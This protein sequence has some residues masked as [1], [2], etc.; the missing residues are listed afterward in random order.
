MKRADAKHLSLTL[1][2]ALTLFVVYL[3]TGYFRR[4]VTSTLAYEGTNA[5]YRVHTIHAPGLPVRIEGNI[6][7]EGERD[8]LKYTITNTSSAGAYDFEIAVYVLNKKGRVKAGQVWRMPVELAANSVDSFSRP[9]TNKPGTGDCVVVAIQEVTHGQNTW[10]VNAIPFLQS[11]QIAVTSD[12]LAT[13]S[14]IVASKPFWTV[15]S[16]HGAR[17]AAYRDGGCGDNF[18]ASQTVAATNACGGPT[19]C[20]VSSFSCD[21]TACTVSWSCNRCLD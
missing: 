20:G 2:I 14:M 10:R 12:A 11:A 5:V 13:A 7:S 4:A 1:G 3:T 18:C 9:L 17:L 6:V 15:D 16:S 21:Q 8:T 19:G